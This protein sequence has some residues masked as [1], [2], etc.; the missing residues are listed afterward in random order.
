MSAAPHRRWTEEEYLAMERDSDTKHEYYQGEVFAM[1]GASPN[2][3]QIAGNTFAGLHSQ[4]RKRDCRVYS[5]D[6]RLRVKTTGLYTYP[7]IK[8]VCGEPEF[9]NDKPQ[10]LLNPTL[11]IEVLSPSTEQYDR[12]KKFQHYRRLAS[13]QE[14]VLISQD[15]PRIERFLRQV[16]GTWVLKEAIGL[17]AVLEL[18]S[19][20]CTLELADVYE[21]VEFENESL[22]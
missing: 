8:V 18:D 2:H 11:I 15:N 20:Q 17:E 1:A 3:D 4:M 16:D 9:T 5:S 22:W 14:Y 12:G 10:T 6:I 19:I 13:L 21:K 7:D